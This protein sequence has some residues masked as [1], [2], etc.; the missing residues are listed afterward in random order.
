MASF[1]P[2]N[3]RILAHFDNIHIEVLARAY[4]EVRFQ[5][6]LSKYESSKNRFL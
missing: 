1:L 2:S 4:Y 5:S 6:V 3:G